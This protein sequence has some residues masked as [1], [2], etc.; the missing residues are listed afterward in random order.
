MPRWC[1]AGEPDVRKIFASLAILLLVAG[2]LTYSTQPEVRSE[3]PV[4]YWV[5]DPAPARTEQIAQFHK[6]MLRRGHLHRETLART[7]DVRR[8]RARAWSPAMRRAIREGNPHGAAVLDGTLAAA[9]LPVEIVYPKAEMRLDSASNDLTKKLIQGLS[10]VAGDVIEAYNGGQQMTYLASAG[11]LADVT[12]A[13]R[14]H[15]FGPDKTY[16]ALAPSLF[17]D[18]RQYAFPRNVAQDLYWVNAETFARHGQPL[19]PS[20]W[21]IESFEARGRAFVEAANREGGRRRVFF[22]DRM[23]MTELRRSLGLSAFNE[24]LTRCTLDDPR[25]ARVLGLLYRWTYEDRILPSAAD[26]ASF[27][28]EG[29]WGLQ[30]FQLFHGGH[31]AMV[32]T[33]RWALMQFRRFGTMDL[34]VVELPHGGL[35]NTL[36]SGGQSTV[37]QAS[38]HRDLAVLFLA[39]MADEEYNRQIVRDADALPPNPAYTRDRAFTHPPDHPNE[40]G[41]HAMVRDAAESI[42]IV[43]SLSPYILPVS[44][45]RHDQRAIAEVM[46]HRMSPEDAAASCAHLINAEIDRVLAENEV[47]R[48]RHAAD[49]ALQA[50]IDA[51]RAAGEPVPED[52]L[53][54]PFHRRW[55]REQGWLAP[56]QPEVA[57]AE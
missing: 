1:A 48:A 56:P 53:L 32:A 14:E 13:A 39:Y 41:C 27:S 29:G 47:L 10:G 30:Q 18:G 37:Y 6:W 42:A 28:N 15:G 35:P 24:T 5:V 11:M 17:V 52:W 9:A 3:V 40:W 20:R 36:L 49:R 46:N 25:N 22:A 43:Q 55:Y 38:H 45:L 2:A 4:L 7:D 50:R 16:T 51:A 12:E 34:R 57:H 8:F 33:G 26:V 54:N 31:Y 21:T 19:P 23:P 44:A